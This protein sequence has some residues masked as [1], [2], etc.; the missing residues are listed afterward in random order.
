[1]AIIIDIMNISKLIG[2]GF[3]LHVSESGRIKHIP[4]SDKK[5]PLCNAGGG[6]GKS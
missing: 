2:M 4:I 6:S 5:P 3:V 1:M